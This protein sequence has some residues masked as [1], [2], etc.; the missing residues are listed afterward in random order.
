MFSVRLRTLFYVRSS[1]LFISCNREVSHSSIS[2]YMK[3]IEK[4]SQDVGIIPSDKC[5][6][7]RLDGCCFGT[8]VKKDPGFNL[9]WDA[10]GI[11]FL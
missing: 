10:R 6:F 9:P 2:G 5:F 11:L 4:K 3:D 1:S 8:L 7:V